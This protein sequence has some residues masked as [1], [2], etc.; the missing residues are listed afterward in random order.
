[1]NMSMVARPVVVLPTAESSIVVTG[2]VHMGGLVLMLA[3]ELVDGWCCDLCGKFAV[4]KTVQ[5][6]IY[7]VD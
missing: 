1:M 2:K 7:S 6:I 5:R 3:M 4:L